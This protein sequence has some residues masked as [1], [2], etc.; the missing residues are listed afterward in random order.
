MKKKVVILIFCIISLLVGITILEINL[1]LHGIPFIVLLMIAS[2]VGVILISLRL[3]HTIG[4]DGENANLAILGVFVTSFFSLLVPFNDG[5]NSFHNIPSF[6][7]P[8]TIKKWSAIELVDIEE[9]HDSNW[10][11]FDDY[12]DTQEIKLSGDTELPDHSLSGNN[13][14][15]DYWVRENIEGRKVEIIT[16]LHPKSFEY[17]LQGDYILNNNIENRLSITELMKTGYI[18]ENGLVD[19]ED[20]KKFYVRNPNREDDFPFTIDVESIVTNDNITTTKISLT[21]KSKFNGEPI[22]ESIDQWNGMLVRG[23]VKNKTSGEYDPVLFLIKV[24]TIFGKET[25]DVTKFMIDG[26]NT[27]AGNYRSWGVPYLITEESKEKLNR[28]LERWGES[29]EPS[30]GFNKKSFMSLES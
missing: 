13:K 9:N 20:N 5:I 26:N 29:I 6:S 3:K 7:V 16:Y 27:I 12:G 1:N 11:R 14:L 19:R 15:S 17:T 8:E 24:H 25:E 10:T 28:Y 21:P 22:T 4:T 18:D 30:I 2:L 23:K